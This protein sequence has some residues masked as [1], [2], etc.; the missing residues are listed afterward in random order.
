MQ[1]QPE[2]GNNL[3]KKLVTKRFKKDKPSYNI[4]F[5]SKP[6]RLKILI[7]NV[8]QFLMREKIQTALT[9]LLTPHRTLATSERGCPNKVPG[10]QLI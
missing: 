9:A 2:N 5:A 7:L 4:S 1:G 8:F 3:G 10:G 6:T